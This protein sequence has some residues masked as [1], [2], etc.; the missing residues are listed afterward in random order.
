MG[1]LFARRRHCAHS[2]VLHQVST[3]DNR[4][5]A[6]EQAGAVGSRHAA[7][8]TAVTPAATAV[9]AAVFVGCPCVNLLAQSNHP[10]L[11]PIS[12]FT[13]I[14]VPLSSSMYG[15][16]RKKNNLLFT[17]FFPKRTKTRYWPDTVVLNTQIAKPYACPRM[18]KIYTHTPQKVVSLSSRGIAGEPQIV[19]LP[20]QKD[21][22]K[23]TRISNHSRYTSIK[24]V[25]YTNGSRAR[26]RVSVLVRRAYMR[27]RLAVARLA[28]REISLS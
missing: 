10:T 22:K 21:A 8:A 9:V 16:Y 11:C 6:N 23:R 26:Y 1:I 17:S 25:Y 15:L 24:P 7:V 3:A 13:G 27:A 12:V 20:A 18:A 19:F 4:E 5:E 28:Q 14:L 2:C